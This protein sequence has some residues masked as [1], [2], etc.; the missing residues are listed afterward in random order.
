MDFFHKYFIVLDLGYQRVNYDIKI[1][2][3][4][5]KTNQNVDKLKYIVTDLED[6]I[7]K[8]KL[9]HCFN[10]FGSFRLMK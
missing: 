1:N 3:L 4:L 9:V 7:V 2:S 6:L 10:L 5:S 8:K